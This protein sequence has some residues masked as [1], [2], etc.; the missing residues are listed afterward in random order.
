MLSKGKADGL[1]LTRKIE[2]FKSN[3]KKKGSLIN[4]KLMLLMR[5]LSRN[6]SKKPKG[7]NRGKNIHQNPELIN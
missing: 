6:R 7:E 2:L 5:V 1:G 4:N 3:R